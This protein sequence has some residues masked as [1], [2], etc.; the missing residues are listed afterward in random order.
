MRG[1]TRRAAATFTD[2]PPTEEQLTLGGLIQ[3]LE[4]RP[5]D[6]RVCFDFASLEVTGLASYRGFYDELAI[7]F[8]ENGKIGTVEGLLE[9]LKL[10][11]G[12]TFEGY[13]G[14]DFMMHRETPLWVAN[15]GCTGS[16]MVVGIR[17]CDWQT[18]IAT[19][20]EAD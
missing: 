12:M 2:R 4:L 10:A 3:Q 15:Y 14:G 18:V 7:G 19:A 11:D 1:I 6:Q 17:E 20:Y 16:T 9:E 13:K 8:A 5:K